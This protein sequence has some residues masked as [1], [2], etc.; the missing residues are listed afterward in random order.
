MKNIF[1]TN[2]AV[3]GVV[4]EEDPDMMV[5]TNLSAEVIQAAYKADGRVTW[6]ECYEVTDQDVGYYL[7]SAC[8]LSESEE[9]RALQLAEGKVAAC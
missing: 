9:R 5:F 4:D 6:D 1:M 2:V 7:Y 3:N 8:W